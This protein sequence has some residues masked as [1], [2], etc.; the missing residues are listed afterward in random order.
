MLR[1][2]KS[3]L[4]SPIV[5]F[6]L[7]IIAVILFLTSFIAIVFVKN[8]QLS[9]DP[10][11]KSSNT[12][13]SDLTVITQKGEW[14]NNNLN[15]KLFLGNQI[16]GS[17]VAQADNLGIISVIFDSQSRSVI[18]KIVF[19]IKQKGDKNWYS[20]NIYNTDQIQ[21]N[22][23]FPFGFS[24]IKNSRGKSYAF[25]IESLSGTLKNFIAVS[26]S[27]YFIKYKFSK[28]ELVNNPFH[29]IKFT[30]AKI[31]EQIK[32]LAEK[33]IAF[34]SFSSISP[35]VLFLILEKLL[36]YFALKRKIIFFWG[37]LNN[38]KNDI[39]SCRHQISLKKLVNFTTKNSLLIL[40]VILLAIISTRF[41][42]SYTDESNMIVAPDIKIRNSPIG[43]DFLV[44]V[45]NP[46]NSMF[47]GGNIN[48]PNQD[49]GPS[50]TLLVTPFVYLSSWFNVCSLE[51]PSSC[52]F[53]F[54]HW[55]LFITV[56][57]YISFIVLMF[58][59]RK[60]SL[61]FCLLLFIAFAL[62][63]PGSL[64][65]ERGNIDI[66]FSLIFGIVLWRILS[67]AEIKKSKNTA[68]F[69]PVMIGF[70]GA[71][72]VS[73]KLF[74]LPIAMVFIYSSRRIFLSLFIFIITFFLLGCL[75]GL[76][77]HSP[78]TPFSVI[79]TAL[80][81]GGAGLFAY[82]YN[83]RLNTSFNA[84]G[85]LMTNCV[86]RFN[87]ESQADA[88]VITMV[89]VFLFI[90]TFIVPFV[91][92]DF[93]K[94]RLFKLSKHIAESLK[95][96]RIFPINL[97][98]AIKLGI[99]WVSRQRLNKYFILLL[100]ILAVA[101]LNLLPRYSFLY[102]LYYSLPLLILLLKETKSNEKAKFYYLLS[103]IC[104]SIRGLWIFI[105]VNPGG[106][107]IFE[108]RGLSLFTVLHYFFLIRTGIELLIV[109]KL[110]RLDFVNNK[111]VRH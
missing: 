12:K 24:I 88:F 91:A 2:N 40:V 78:S 111:G 61:V 6:V 71:F 80:K 38:I 93:I 21:T 42:I 27:N 47:H 69:M 79:N 17:F 77:Y 51:Y 7:S 108:S 31:S 18:D 66:I 99:S 76:L 49:Y 63:T 9:N 11:Y 46:L 102:R 70:I 41:L 8:L 59:R 15:K 72:L 22:I 110:S 37:W 104:L 85:S 4:R 82:D 29:L 36:G 48:A 39:Y 97:I 23:P 25:Q 3:L 43:A 100:S 106:F 20:Q 62:S 30:I 109:N 107:N 81:W 90:F 101:S 10:Y 19:R 103:I 87:C 1:D 28:L 33:E 105:G 45:A 64:G 95:A 13:Y 83:M 26:N 53:V 75:P 98:R 94:L 5:L 58:Y 50:F 60:E 89:S 86:Q 34:I 16:N 54:Y 84:I 67:G 74:L 92:T 32:L 96:G 57:G 73:S 52:T 44:G 65:L 55:L 35:F 56:I 14:E 68:I